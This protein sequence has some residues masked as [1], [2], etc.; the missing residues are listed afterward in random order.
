MLVM[1]MYVSVSMVFFMIVYYCLILVGS[2][3]R[4]KMVSLIRKIMIVLKLR[5]IGV[6]FCIRVCGGFG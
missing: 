1:V 2:C 3:W 5:M 4:L 6:S